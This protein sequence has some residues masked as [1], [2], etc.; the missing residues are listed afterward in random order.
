M[1]ARSRKCTLRVGH[2]HRAAPIAP[3]WPESDPR[4]AWGAAWFRRRADARPFLEGAAPDCLRVLDLLIVVLGLRH[5]LRRPDDVCRHGA[6]LIRG[7][8]AIA[9]GRVGRRGNEDDVPLEVL[10]AHAEITEEAC[11]VLNDDRVAHSEDVATLPVGESEGCDRKERVRHAAARGALGDEGWVRVCVP[12]RMHMHVCPR[13]NVVHRYT[14]AGGVASEPSMY[15]QC[16]CNGT[17]QHT[18]ASTRLGG[19][20]TFRR[21]ASLCARGLGL[22]C[23][24]GRRCEALGKVCAARSTRGGPVRELRASGGGKA[25][26]AKRVRCDACV[27]GA[28]VASRADCPFRGRGCGSG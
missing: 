27:V 17:Q 15:R 24:G 25:A 22:W 7:A 20:R 3:N 23:A 11:D 21:G 13:A 16:P 28:Y 12:P 9:T 26:R 10:R 2:A 8:H 5:V 4:G 6:P 19:A 18:H 14:R 1:D